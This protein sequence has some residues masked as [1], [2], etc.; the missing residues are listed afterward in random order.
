[1]S[2]P[3]D[4]EPVLERFSQDMRAKLALPKNVRKPHWTESDLSY[5]LDRLDDEVL[6]L[7][8]ACENR[9]CPEDAT[10]IR[11]EAVDV[12]NFAMMIADWVGK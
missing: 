10:A 4:Y 5:L 8:T 11:S 7:K 6:E 1:M 9:T 2:G 3:K 12:A